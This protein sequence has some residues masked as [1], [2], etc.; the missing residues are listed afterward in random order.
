MFSPFSKTRSQCMFWFQVASHFLYCGRAG[1]VGGGG[2][3]G[4]GLL[5]FV[6]SGFWLVL[7]LIQIVS[8]GFI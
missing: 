5:L 4:G 8:S 7:T 1:G 6:F 2:G 3:G